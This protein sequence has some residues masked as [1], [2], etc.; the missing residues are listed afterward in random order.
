[1]LGAGRGG[2][3]AQH[4]H[5]LRAAALR[6]GLDPRGG[7]G[8]RR[9]R[10]RDHRGH[11]RPRRASR[12]QHDQARPSRYA[13]G[14][15]QLP[16]H[17]L[18]RQDQRGHHP[19]VVLQG[20]QR[21]RGVALGHADL[22]DRQ[23]DRPGR[24]RLLHD[25]GHRRRSGGRLLLR[26]HPRAVRGRRGDR[27]GGPLGRDR[28][29]GRGEG[30][31]VH[32][33]EHEQAGGRLH[34]RLHR[35]GGQAD[36]PRR[37]DRLGQRRD[38]RGQGPGAR[39]QGR[40][41]RSHA[42]RSRQDRGRGP[43]RRVAQHLLRST[44]PTAG[45]ERNKALPKLAGAWSQGYCRAMASGV[46]TVGSGLSIR[47]CIPASVLR[48]STAAWGAIAATSLFLLITCWFVIEDRS[49]PIFDAGLHLQLALEVHRELAAG[50]LTKALTV[51]VPYPPFPYLVESLGLA[52]GGIGV[53]Q[54]ILAE[55]FVFIP[56]LALG[57]YHVG[58][59]TFGATA[60]FLAVVF[61]FGSPLIIS[62]FHVVMIDGPEATM[63]AVSL[64]A[65]LAS[66]RFSRIGV[67]ALA[68]LCVGLGMLTKEPAAF[69]VA[70]PLVV[71]LL[72]GGWRRW[73]G[74]LAFAVVALAVSL[75]WYISELS[76]VNGIASGALTSPSSAGLPADI[77]PHPLSLDN[78]EWYAWNLINAQLYMPLFA[79]AAIG[80]IWTIIGFLRQRWVSPLA[81]E[82]TI[83]A[84]V[85]WLGIT[86]TFA[87]DTRYSMPLLVYLAVF[88]AGWVI[89]LPRRW[90]WGLG[91]ALV[92]VAVVNT[93][94]IIFEVGED[95]R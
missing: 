86:E 41:G 57:C 45:S 58:R 46:P 51:S 42:H 44:Q 32:R 48:W 55:N 54:P 11:P 91:A 1:Q 47:P 64:W 92:T 31:G 16:R 78:F 27:A 76:L 87:H 72:R 36:G 68:G 4:G 60:G 23:R 30:G 65:I 56:L 49:I 26:G 84:F 43:R 52:I 53:A 14:R 24:L 7:R 59:L 50:H 33:R 17:P 29:L 61:A 62:M 9:A 12:V 66:E 10:D 94:G 74:L 93:V 90:S 70:G 73:R 81:P 37:R 67:S 80:W 35:P 75:P 39:S 3:T 71:A 22:P 34:R 8:R 6:R 79:F 2:V 5:D 89:H 63:V 85:G 82:I 15:P 69:F 21:G 77:A 28:R 19:G 13:T 83:G 18:P 38:G 20:R 95:I 25:R 40:T 88:G